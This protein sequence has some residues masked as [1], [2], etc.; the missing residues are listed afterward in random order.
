MAITNSGKRYTKDLPGGL[1]MDV[2]PFQCSCD[3]CGKT[4]YKSGED[5]GDAADAARKEGFST[6]SVGAAEPM[7]WACKECKSKTA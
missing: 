3:W 2:V 1:W 5:P 7:K 6:V 4:A